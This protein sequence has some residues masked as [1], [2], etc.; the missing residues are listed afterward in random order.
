VLN[1][2]FDP[3]AEYSEDTAGSPPSTG[4]DHTAHG[5]HSGHPP[6]R[7][8]TPGSAASVQ[9]DHASHVAPQ[10]EGLEQAPSP[11]APTYTCPMHP[12]IVR[13]RPGTCPSCGMKLVPKKLPKPAP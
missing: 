4:H 7:P 13:D 10:G 1:A 2:S 3:F 12:E 5:A 9:H 11:T 6:T 8:G